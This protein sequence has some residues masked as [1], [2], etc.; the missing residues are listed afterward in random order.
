MA[1]N[2]QPQVVVTGLGAITPLG[3]DVPATWSAM[4]AGT[5]GVRE[6]SPD[7]VDTTPVRIAAPAAVEPESVLDRIHAGAWTGTSSLA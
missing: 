6:I 1:G 7:W 4:L 2:E 3:G 5:S